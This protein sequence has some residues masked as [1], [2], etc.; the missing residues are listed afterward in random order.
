[1]RRPPRRGQFKLQGP[2]LIGLAKA[3]NDHEKK[4]EA[5]WRNV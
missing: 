5:A 1:M 3:F 2:T 4:N